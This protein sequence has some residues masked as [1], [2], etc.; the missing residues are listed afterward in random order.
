MREPALISAT[1][2]AHLHLLDDFSVEMTG[3]D[4]TGLVDARAL[5]PAGTRVNVTYLGS[6]NL[7]MRLKA[8]RT[9]GDLGFRPVPHI[10]ARRQTSTAE[11]REFLAGLQ[12]DGTG[13]DVFVVGG[14]PSAPHGPYPDALSVIRSGLLHEYGVR[15]IG[16]AGYPEGHPAIPEH[17]LWG[18]LADK[19]GEL[20]A[21]GLAGSVITQF[22][23]DSDAALA[24][25]QRVREVGID[26]PV[27][28]GVPGPAGVRRLMSFATR[29]GVGTSAS[30]AKKYGLSLTG[31]VGTAGPGRFL[32]SLTE[33][34]DPRL[35]GEVNVHFYTFGG[36][37]A[38]AEWVARFKEEAR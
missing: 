7:P 16:I 11:L 5:L 6:E 35:H 34:Y 14:D 15:H 9:A 22:G 28:V 33:S 1:A 17:A 23:F 3:K 30:I 2:G 4:V 24:W 38:S 18:A 10:S 13:R 37:K 12:A 19:Y 31:L 21:Q 25:I 26:L 36:L 27:R 20:R 32:R 8:A 29:F